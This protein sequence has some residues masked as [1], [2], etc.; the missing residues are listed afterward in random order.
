MSLS[1]RGYLRYRGGGRESQARM[2]IKN[3]KRKGGQG[4]VQKESRGEEGEG[5]DSSRLISKE[6]V[7]IFGK[8]TENRPLKLKNGEWGRKK[9]GSKGAS[10]VRF[11]VKKTQLDRW[12]A[13]TSG[14]GQG[15][16]KG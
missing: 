1:V 4:K 10:R 12:R 16:E 9:K 3:R 8:F 15:G 5:V 11:S 6:R 2:S 14:G 13:A 7:Q